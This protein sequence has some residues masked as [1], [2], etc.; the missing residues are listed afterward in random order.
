[1]RRALVACECSGRI[2]SALR[3]RG[4]DAWSVDLLPAEDASP[5]HVQGDAITM[6]GDGWDLLIAHPP[7]D[8]LANSGVRWRVE[9][10]EWQQVADAA[11][12]FL[13]FWRAP[14][15]C[16]AIENP[17]MHRYGRAHIVECGT[18]W[19]V[20][21]WQFGDDLK[22]RTCWWTRGLPR[23]VPTSA[24]D[25]STARDECHREPPGPN[26]K[27]NRSRTPLGMAEAIAE[28]WGQPLPLWRAA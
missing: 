6:L 5:Y 28:Q 14:V 15:P 26:R 4:V 23:L 16:V 1:M 11:A 9:R 20:Q 27:R 21:P 19:S 7:C 18:P 22:K 24:L 25:G 12:L 8:Y 3:R 10:Q 2:R 13:A 17:V